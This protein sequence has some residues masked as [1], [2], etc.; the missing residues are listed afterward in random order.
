MTTKDVKEMQVKQAAHPGDFS[1]FENAQDIREGLNDV[2][3]G[4]ILTVAA[5]AHRIG[6]FREIYCSEVE[7]KL[8]EY[9]P[10]VAYNLIPTTDITVN[11]PGWG[12]YICVSIGPG[13]FGWS[14]GCSMASAITE[15]WADESIRKY[16]PY[17]GY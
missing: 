1:L 12:G 13:W 2:E 17:E 11:L 3:I 16:E 6:K 4:S 9:P 14:L 8:N 7:A 5:I 10:D 15:I